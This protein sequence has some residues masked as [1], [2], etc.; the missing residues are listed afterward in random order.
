MAADCSI[1]QR[2]FSFPDRCVAGRV[3]PVIHS[4]TH[5]VCVLDHAMRDVAVQELLRA[6]VSNVLWRGAFD[7][8]AVSLG[9]FLA[10]LAEFMLVPRPRSTMSVID[11]VPCRLARE[12]LAF[13]SIHPS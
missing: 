6:L 13:H 2:I 9:H 8:T 12:D 10:A 3:C 1:Q 4:S 5:H 11:M 7:G